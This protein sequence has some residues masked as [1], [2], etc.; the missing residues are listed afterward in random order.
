MVAGEDQEQYLNRIYEAG[1]NGNLPVL[2]QAASN[3]RGDDT[4]A[5]ALDLL[6]Q[7][8]P[9]QA[10]AVAVN[11]SSSSELGQ[12]VTGLAALGRI[13]SEQSIKALGQALGDPDEGVKEIA[14]Q[15]LAEEGGP[16]AFR[17]IKQAALDTNPSLRSIAQAL[18][19]GD[20]ESAGDGSGTAAREA[21]SFTIR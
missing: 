17:L 5:V 12:R 16:E 4:Q 7:R 10:I 21:Q 14:L 15:G 11:A 6:S 18:L 13:R 3:P 8:D 2:K 9:S 19:A 20:T 1:Q